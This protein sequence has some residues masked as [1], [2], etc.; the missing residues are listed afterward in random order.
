MLVVILQI[1]GDKLQAFVALRH[2]LRLIGPVRADRLCP[3]VGRILGS[4][5]DISV[6][7]TLSGSAAR[8]RFRASRRSRMST[9]LRPS[10]QP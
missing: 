9:S 7:Y 8:C 1:L 2:G 6:S 4:C 10:D 3:A 5:S